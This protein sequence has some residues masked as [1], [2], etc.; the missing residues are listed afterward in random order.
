MPSSSTYR[1]ALTAS[2]TYFL[3][4]ALRAAAGFISMPVLTRAM[5]KEQYGLLNIT[6]ATVGV[7]VLAGRLGFAEAATRFYYERSRQGLRSLREF[8]SSMLAGSFISG[9]LVALITVVVLHWAAPQETVAR[10][11]RAGALIVI[12]RAVLGVIYQIYRAQERPV[13]YSMAQIATRYASLAVA[14]A[15]LLAY[16]LS[17][18]DVI[19]ATVIGEGLVVLVGLAEFAARGIVGRPSLARANLNAAFAYGVPLAVGLSGT[20]LLDYGDRFLIERFLGLDAVATYS[21]PY[22]L[23]SSLS[24]AVFGSL[25]LAV[26]PVIF[27]LWETDGAA[28][29]S[30]FVSQVFTYSVALAIPGIALFIAVSEE[31]IVLIASGKYGGSAALTAFLTPGVLMGELNFL[32]AAGLLISGG[33]VALAAL[34]LVSTAVNLALNVVLL[35]KWGLV[36]AAWATTIAYALF[37]LSTYLLARRSLE[38]RVKPLV[39]GIALLTTAIMLLVLNLLGRPSSQ[40]AVDLLLR[41]SVGAVVACVCMSLMDH[42]IRQRTWW[43]AARSIRPRLGAA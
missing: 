41:G 13:A 36:G 43:R 16:G 33:T 7:L 11:L 30:D 15:M 26:M 35:P 29:T 10:C 6:L 28:A 12:V 21:V 37:M 31:F 8:C 38:I 20:F 42:E 2:G 25:K 17:A 27:R 22:D 40:P 3:F 5:S 9:A 14:I 1:A 23:A 34:T 18:Y 19:V 32:V 39:L 24:A 4:Q